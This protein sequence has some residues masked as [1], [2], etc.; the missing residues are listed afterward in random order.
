MGRH[1]RRAHIG[2]F[3]RDAARMIVTHLVEAHAPLGDHPLLERARDWWRSTIQRRRPFCISCGANF[4]DNAVAGAFL[5]GVPSDASKLASVAV[6]CAQCFS[7]LP[8]ETIDAEAARV[9][10]QVIPGGKFI[11]GAWP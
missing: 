10:Q 6:F 4:A 8:P 11:D 5:F 7:E 2:R 3:R 9:L 1:E